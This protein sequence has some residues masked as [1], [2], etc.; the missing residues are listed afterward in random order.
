MSLAQELNEHEE[1][2]HAAH[3]LECK[4][5]GRK[6]P[7]QEGHF[8]MVDKIASAPR[9]LSRGPQVSFG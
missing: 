2:T 9:T 5:S 1:Y 8:I 4:V 6:A 7:S 3:S